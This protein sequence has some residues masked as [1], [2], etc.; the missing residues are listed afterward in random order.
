[1]FWTILECIGWLVGIG[2]LSFILFVLYIFVSA[3]NS[4]EN[5]FR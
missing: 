3:M 1:M 4:G 2:A 5:L